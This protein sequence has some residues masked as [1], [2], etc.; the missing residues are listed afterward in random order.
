MYQ[1]ELNFLVLGKG[2]RSNSSTMPPPYT[3]VHLLVCTLNVCPG[4]FN[5]LGVGIRLGVN[6]QGRGEGGGGGGP[7]GLLTLGP[8]V[9]HGAR[10]GLV[11]FICV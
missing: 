4:A 6:K 2:C 1:I 7:G 8:V 10:A 9:K 5:C 11:S 3:P